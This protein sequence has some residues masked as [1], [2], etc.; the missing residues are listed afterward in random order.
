MAIAQ[1]EYQTTVSGKIVENKLKQRFS[2]TVMLQLYYALIHP[3]LLSSIND[4]WK[5]IS[6]LYSQIKFVQNPA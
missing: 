6:Y 5:L 3:F 2:H 4:M 1:L